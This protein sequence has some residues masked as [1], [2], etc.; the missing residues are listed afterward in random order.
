[1]AYVPSQLW[2]FPLVQPLMQGPGVALPIKAQ[3]AI[4][5][6]DKDSE[7][8]Q[9]DQ[10]PGM[11]QGSRWILEAGFPWSLQAQK[12]IHIGARLSLLQPPG[13]PPAA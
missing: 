10:G 1:M 5:E 4:Q 6:P 12:H 2:P 9:K 7:R 8:W 13:Q 11:G 3:S